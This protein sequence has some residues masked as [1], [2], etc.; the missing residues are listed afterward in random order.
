MILTHLD[1]LLINAKLFSKIVLILRRYSHEQIQYICSIMKHPQVRLGDD[2]AESNMFSVIFQCFFSS[3]LKGHLH[4]FF[5]LFVSFIYS[6]S[7]GPP[8]H[9]KPNLGKL[10]LVNQGP[11]GVS[12]AGKICG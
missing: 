12:F 9:G 5:K 11:K 10:Q 3:H 4:K 7:V 1:S 6:N 8:I 2:T